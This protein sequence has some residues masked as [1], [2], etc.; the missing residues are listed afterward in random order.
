MSVIVWVVD[1]D[2]ALFAFLVDV[3]RAFG[4]DARGVHG[5]AAF[6][7]AFAAIGRGHPQVLSIDYAMP[8]LDG[9]ATLRAARRAGFS[10]PALMLSGQIDLP[11][12]VEAMREGMLT[13]QTKPV[14]LEE[15]AAQISEAVALAEE[16]QRRR[17]ERERQAA[18]F[19]VL[20]SRESDV[21]AALGE[22]LMNKQVADRLGLSIKTVETH[23]HHLMEKLGLNTA[24]ALMRC[25]V[26]Y[27]LRRD[28]GE[29]H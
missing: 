13:V 14:D 6:L 4:F 10:G 1:D 17:E 27:R 28:G 19:R 22:G 15:Y 3:L 5:G 7:E 11:H 2:E 25:A 8:G 20:T 21:F 26:E 24:G 16:E 12:V 18:R 9:I 29:Q 23:R